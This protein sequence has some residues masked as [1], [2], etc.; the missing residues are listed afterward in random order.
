MDKSH[1][2]ME[3]HICPICSET[4]DTGVIL[5]D[6]HL[7]KVFGTKTLTGI[8]YCDKC[9]EMLK[10]YIALVSIDESKSERLPNGR[11]SPEGAYRLG[12]IIWVKREAA[13]KIIKI[14]IDTFAFTDVSVINQFKQIKE[15]NT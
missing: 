8:S 9:K 7:R 3:E 2:T 10:D 13:S 4:Y 5:L 6:T 1:V 11:I 15:E 14:P 12:E